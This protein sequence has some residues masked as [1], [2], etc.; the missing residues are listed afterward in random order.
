M[1]KKSKDLQQET[2][3]MDFLQS[4][5]RRWIT[6]YIPL[7]IFV[8]VLL[9]PFYWMVITAFKPDNELLRQT[10]NPFWVVAP[11]LAHFKKLLFETQYPAW[12]LNTVI[13]SVV[14][15]FASLAASV[16]AA[17]AI[18]RLRFQ[19]SKQV[20]LGIFLAYL[21]P[22]SILFIP[23]AAIVFKL[24]LFDTRWALILTYPTFLIPFCTWLLMGY[25]RSIPYELEECALIDGATRWEI[26]IKII[27][28]L[29]VPGLISAGIFAFT[30][31]WNEFIY[32]LTFISSS[33]VKTVPVGIVTELVDGDVYH[34]GALMAGALLG[35]LPVAVV[36]SFFV[37]YYVS[38]MTGAVKE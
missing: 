31:S 30:L 29:A 17:Y 6:T 22:P 8:F 3:G 10:G 34:W 36:Y 12:L 28:P 14:S 23:L 32:A 11:T 18:E 26:L 33:E 16:F 35:S 13:V 1:S 27:L 19:G 38:G 2:Q 20:G 25:F 9:F 5:P 24:G 21:I 15:T 4:V 7:G 37:E